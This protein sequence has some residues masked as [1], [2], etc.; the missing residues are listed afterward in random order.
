MSGLRARRNRRLEAFAG[1][2]GAIAD[3]EDIRIPGGLQRRLRHQVVRAVHFESVEVAQDVRPA[4]AG[5]PDHELGRNEV[6]AGQFHPVGAH[7]RDARVGSHL[8]AELLQKR[9]GRVG[10]A[11]GE[12]RQN[13]FGALDQNDTKSLSAST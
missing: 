7:R 12:R 3:R 2:G 9:K 10:D 5:R 6:A 1:D 4:H 8:H 13:A 11:L